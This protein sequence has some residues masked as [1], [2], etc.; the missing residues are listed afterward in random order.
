MLSYQANYVDALRD[1]V[2]ALSSPR[3]T[4]IVVALLAAIQ[5][6]ATIYVCGNG[7]SASMADHF[8]IDLM[9]LA[10]H[11]RVQSLSSN[12]A[13]LTA[14]ANDASYADIFT[15][16]LRN[17][18]PGDVLIAISSSGRSENVLRAARLMVNAGG[19][20]IGISGRMPWENNQ[21]LNLSSL[22]LDIPSD[23]TQ[24]IEDVTGSVLHLLA[25]ATGAIRG[26]EV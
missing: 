11:S 3:V 8:V 26:V 20:V 23:D 5:R 13:V 4:D 10:G 21:L 7:G 12:T 2:E 19:V 18:E 17:A 22:R 6:D 14:T 16:Q 1:A 24:I 25:R 15:A 9:K